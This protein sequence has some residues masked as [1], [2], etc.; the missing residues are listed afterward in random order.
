MNAAIRCATIVTLLLS[1]LA[2]PVFGQ[3]KN[4]D[5]ALDATLA[6]L[7]AEHEF[8]GRIEQQLE[9]RLGRK[10]DPQ[11]ADLGRNLFFDPILALRKDNSCAGC[12]APQ[13]GFADSQSIAIGIRNNNVVGPLRTGPRNQRRSP[14][15]L[16][17]AFFPALMWNGRFS[18][19]SNDPFD[20]SLGFIFPLPEGTT[21]FP[22]GDARFESLLAAQGHIPQTELVEM[23]GFGGVTGDDDIDASFYQ[24]DDGVGIELPG[25]D[26]SG[27]RNEPIRDRVLVELNDNE[28]YRQLFGRVFREVRGGAPIDFAMVGTAIAEFEFTLTFA[29]API[30]R[31]ARGNTG[32]MSDAQKRGA[33]LFFGEANCVSC[34]RV[35]GSANE[36][37]SDFA[38]HRLGVP[39][40]APAFG[41]NTGNVHFDG[42]NADEDFGAAQI[43]GEVDDRYKFRTSPLRNIALQPTFFHNGSFT[44]LADAVRHHLNVQLS[45][46]AYDPSVAGVAPDLK[47]TSAPVQNL[48]GDL[49][50]LVAE[51]LVLTDEEFSD[52]VEFV[53]A[54]LLDERAT[55]E[56]LLK[57]VPRE[58]PSGLP[59]HE[60]TLGN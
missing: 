32:A 3:G 41:L 9:L 16:N 47:L 60:F 34:H 22:A 46:A 6:D 48:L 5:N 18:A 54:G 33:I 26:D 7:L 13:F 1:T 45:L 4:G 50:P 35:D 12:H 29:D 56:R 44:Q 37:F 23:A 58:L 2:A 38:N 30:D 14:T 21:R 49:D 39:Q 52:L 15:L 11:L 8:T 17:S 36:M 25:P 43:S 27:F 42:P 31:F 28:N 59:V 57:L 20:N 10:I 24:F 19:V 51:P 55:P 53:G 40:L